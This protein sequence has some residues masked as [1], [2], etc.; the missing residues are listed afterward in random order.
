MIIMEQLIQ[1]T[2]NDLSLFREHNAKLLKQQLFE[3]PELVPEVILPLGVPMV[4]LRV[5]DVSLS[6]IGLGT[7]IDLAKLLLITH[8]QVNVTMNIIY[9]GH[10][11]VLISSLCSWAKGKRQLFL[12]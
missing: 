12:V 9:Y 11:L 10:K 8:S 3:T 1:F 7:E 4:K 5:A 6:I 2:D